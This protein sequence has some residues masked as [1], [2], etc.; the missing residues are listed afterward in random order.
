[1]RHALVAESYKAE[2]RTEIDQLSK[3]VLAMD[4]LISDLENE[5]KEIIKLDDEDRNLL[6]EEHK[7]YKTEQFNI[8]FELKD[9]ID[10]CL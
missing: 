4:D 9:E 7:A 6:I 8:V 1:M 5:A 3:E 2:I 10:T